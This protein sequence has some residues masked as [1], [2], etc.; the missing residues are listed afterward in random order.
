MASGLFL[1]V[2]DPNV[3][4]AKLPFSSLDKFLWARVQYSVMQGGGDWFAPKGYLT[5]YF[6]EHAVRAIEANAGRPFFLYLA[7]WGAHTPLQATKEDYEAVGDI[8]PHRKRVYAGMM[9]SLDRSVGRIMDKLEAEGIADNTI[10]VLSSDNGAADYI[11]VDGVNAPYRGW[12]NTF[13]EGGLK[14]PMSVTWPGKIAPGTKI[15]APVTHLDLMPTLVSAGGGALPVDRDID[16][17]D[18]TPLWTGSDRLTRPDDAIHWGTP[19]YRVVQAGGWK[20]QINP[21]FDQGW[22]FN[23]NDDPTEQTNLI[24][25]EP[26][27]VAELTALIE[28]HWAGSQPLA[29]SVV[30]GP[31]AIDKH[32]ADEFVAG[33]A[34]V[35]WPN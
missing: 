2:D 15:D 33:D 35:Y 7:H 32:L 21:R 1:P 8:Q 4:N 22:L 31:L 18:M 10:V 34:F 3:V 27:K 6:T 12:K 30:A 11:G 26:E 23:L 9:H 19:D 16:G 17:H 14:I 28:A 24:D 13:F 29:Q 20:L 25:E 5:D